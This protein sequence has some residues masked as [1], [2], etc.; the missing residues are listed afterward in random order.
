[1]SADQVVTVCKAEPVHQGDV[2]LGR[3]IDITEPAPDFRGATLV[4]DAAAFWQAQAALIHEALTSALPGGTLSN[5]FALMAADRA[6]MYRVLDPAADRL[7]KPQV[8]EL[9]AQVAAALAIHK[10]NEFDETVCTS[11]VDSYENP[12]DWPCPTAQALGVS[13]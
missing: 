5:L 10:P 7:A 3:C 12:L 11:C 6:S 13:T 8:A 1:M 9:Q 4:A 2:V